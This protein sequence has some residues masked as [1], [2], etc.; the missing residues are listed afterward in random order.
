MPTEIYKGIFVPDRIQTD[1]FLKSRAHQF[2]ST[3]SDVRYANWQTALNVASSTY[4]I[5]MDAYKADLKAIQEI[6]NAAAKQI[7]A[8]DREAERL[9][10]D[11]TETDEKQ[12]QQANN[13]VTN[14]E[15][16]N[17]NQVNA[18][19]RAQ[20]NARAAASRAAYYKETKEPTIP[21]AIRQSAETAIGQ[22]N[23]TS[24]STAFQNFENS[25][26]MAGQATNVRA[27]NRNLAMPI[28]L[29][30]TDLSTPAAVDNLIAEID[31]STMSMSQK[32][33]YIGAIQS[34]AA[35]RQGQGG[36]PEV[37]G[38]PGVAT[39]GVRAPNYDE[40][41][42]QKLRRLYELGGFQAVRAILPT[43]VT[44]EQFLKDF[45]L[46]KSKGK[47][48]TIQEEYN[49]IVADRGPLTKPGSDVIGEARRIYSANY[50]QN[51]YLARNRAIV[52]GL[53]DR[54]NYYK[55]IRKTDENGKETDT[56]LFTPEEARDRAFND[57]MNFVADVPE[58]A[59]KAK[60]EAP[61]PTPDDN[62][63]AP[64]VPD[65]GMSEYYG[66]APDVGD[67]LVS[68][69]SRR[70]STVP[71]APATPVATEPTPENVKPDAEDAGLLA[72]EGIRYNPRPVPG[73]TGGLNI[74][75]TAIANQQQAARR[76]QVQPPIMDANDVVSGLSAGTSEIPAA[77]PA[78]TQPTRGTSATGSIRTT[79]NAPSGATS[80]MTVAAALEIGQPFIVAASDNSV[81]Y[82]YDPR[83]KTFTL[84]TSGGVAV[85]NQ[86]PV[87]EGD[88][89]WDEL[90]NDPKY[91]ARPVPVPTAPKESPATPANTRPGAPGGSPRAAASPTQT[92]QQKLADLLVT[93]T[94]LADK[95]AK[96]NR[97]LNNTPAGN[98]VKSLMAA[99]GK[100][101]TSQSFIDLRNEI[102]RAYRGKPEQRDHA[103]SLLAAAFI[104]ETRPASTKA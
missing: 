43:D 50:E 21:D 93:G 98:L 48:A 89:R 3:Y 13:A 103:V 31:S 78:L 79:D 19:K 74:G 11:Y 62:A 87:K 92:E 33:A 34:E 38:S 29:K 88:P 10:T 47:K 71:T 81:G 35:K 40:Q 16:F 8:L 49:Q 45:N 95:P 27:A 44:E 56:P 23:N 63:R 2:L 12:V 67:E 5:E 52:S 53:T 14:T 22:T 102:Y 37:P 97:L 46:E 30:D 24:R 55:G 60:P 41:Q 76:L 94:E 68:L 82:V 101:R 18:M 100:L 83:T 90:V 39:V 64:I 28:L 104:L 96:L 91:V 59:P 25:S 26:A 36:T 42:A 85:T 1:Q 54:M 99:N 66:N 86:P 84:T 6:D 4:K 80:S 70:A 17:A 7:A 20:Y 15:R 51:P 65:T 73:R 75:A 77:A 9:R 57:L 32:Q 58:Q 61:P 69:L 72:G